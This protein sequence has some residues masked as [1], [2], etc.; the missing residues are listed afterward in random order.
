MASTCQRRSKASPVVHSAGMKRVVVL[1]AILIAGTIVGGLLIG[2]PT[3]R[4]RAILAPP[5][6]LLTDAAKREVLSHCKGPSFPEVATLR[7]GP[8]VPFPGG[9]LVVASAPDGL[10]SCTSTGTYTWDQVTPLTPD[11]KVKECGNLTSGTEAYAGF[12]L[13]AQEVARVEIGVSSDTYK[14]AQVANGMYAY[15][16]PGSYPDSGRELRA[17]DDTGHVIFDT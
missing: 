4:G 7:L 12:G 3:I 8:A 9:Y 6:Q 2:P 13:A 5:P 17:Y 16:G 14:E 15:F 11:V 10:H 1:T